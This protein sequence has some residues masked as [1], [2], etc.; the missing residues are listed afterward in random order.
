VPAL[1]LGIAC[2]ESFRGGWIFVVI[3]GSAASSE[4][5]DAEVV[6]ALVTFTY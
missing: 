2:F 4:I 3:I 6:G 5:F 1:E